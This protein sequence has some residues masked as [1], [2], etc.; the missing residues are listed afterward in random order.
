M[1]KRYVKITEYHS[2]IEDTIYLYDREKKRIVSVDVETGETDV[3]KEE[4]STLAAA[5]RDFA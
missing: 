2:S 3:V 1:K 5:R 4:I